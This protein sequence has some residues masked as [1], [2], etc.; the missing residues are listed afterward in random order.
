M[1]LFGFLLLLLVAAFCGALGQALAGYSL[2]GCVV[3]SLIG[4]L[5][6]LLGTWLAGALGLPAILVVRVGGEPFPVVWAVLGAALLAL[7]ASVL[8]RPRYV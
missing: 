6:A 4:F 5:G 3:S 8:S 2:G 7:A 1:N